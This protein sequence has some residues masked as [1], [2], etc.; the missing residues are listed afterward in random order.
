MILIFYILLTPDNKNKKEKLILFFSIYSLF[1]FFL[2]LIYII[3]PKQEYMSNI[4]LLVFARVN[5]QVF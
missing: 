3:F 1:F 5:L 4:T 2:N